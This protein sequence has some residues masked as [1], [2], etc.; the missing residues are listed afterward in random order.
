MQNW[1]LNDTW[2][3][4]WVSSGTVMQ[5]NVPEGVL[6]NIGMGLL[7]AVS[8]TPPVIFT[9]AKSIHLFEAK[10]LRWFMTRPWCLISSF[11]R[12]FG[13]DCLFSAMRMS[14]MALERATTTRL[15]F[16]KAVRLSEERTS[17][18]VRLTS[19]IVTT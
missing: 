14:A 4:R 10:P 2:K 1:C 3:R 7:S 15:T 18:L 12:Q 11:G 8:G 17:V 16:T 5:L 6:L 9:I 13:Q 19:L